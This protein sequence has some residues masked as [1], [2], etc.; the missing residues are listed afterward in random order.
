MSGDQLPNTITDQ[1]WA[2][3]QASACKANPRLD[4]FSAP[5]AVERR[6]QSAQQFKNRQWS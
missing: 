5:E 3:L 6:K 2:R 1:Q 4:C